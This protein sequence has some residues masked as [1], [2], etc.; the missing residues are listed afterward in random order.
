MS[1]IILI[2]GKKRHGKD[3]LAEELEKKLIK[4]G[5]SVSVMSFAYPIKDICAESL[6]V[7]IEH[8]DNVKND[9][10]FSGINVYTPDSDSNITGRKYLQLFGTES[11][12]KWFGENVWVDLLLSRAA[13]SDDEFILVPDFR[14]LTENLE[15]AKTVNITNKEIVSTDTHRSEN[16]LNDFVFDYYIDNTGKPDL[17]EQIEDLLKEFVYF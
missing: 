9:P 13:L 8:L 1:Q 11:M 2:N 5:H 16:D 12:Q 6:D 17:S 3:Y 14:F 15:G 7:S 10:N 4:L